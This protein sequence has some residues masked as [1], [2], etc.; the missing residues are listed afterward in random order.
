M[1]PLLAPTWLEELFPGS[2]VAASRLPWGFRNE[3][4]KVELAD[5]RRLAVTRL[6]DRR[7]AG[8]TPTLV[9]RVQPRLADAGLPV[10]ALVGHPGSWPEDVL[11]TTFTDGEPGAALLSG[12]S[13]PRSVG[14]LCGTAWRQLIEVDPTGLGLP[15][16]WAASDRLARAARVWAAALGPELGETDRTELEDLMALL[17]GLL[18]GRPATLVHGD[19]V[20]VNV[21]VRDGQLA[22][23]LDLESV[24][25]A[26][27]LLD[28]AWFDRI[29]WFHHPSEHPAAWSG[30][31]RAAGL[32]P[33]EPTTQ[34]LLHVLPIIRILELIDGLDPDAHAARPRCIAQLQAFLRAGS[35]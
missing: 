33:Y 10:P 6:L 29:V 18:A 35:G 31:T 22:A 23:L 26:D 5:G 20:P 21:L 11:V 24:R 14:S 12:P 16:L 27:P 30:F 7:S 8:V 28:A 9:A 25:L 17:P 15:D 2:M 19:L 4:W 13:G 34:A 3:T 1:T 32:D